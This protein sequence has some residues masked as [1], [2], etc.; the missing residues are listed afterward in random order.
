MSIAGETLSQPEDGNEEAHYRVDLGAIIVRASEAPAV[1]EAL[2][3]QAASCG[4]GE[5]EGFCITVG[6]TASGHVRYEQIRELN[7]RLGALGRG[8]VRRAY[9]VGPRG[10]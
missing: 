9:K 7:R 1:V 3:K 8:F 10:E 4:L 6:V 2:K 5:Q